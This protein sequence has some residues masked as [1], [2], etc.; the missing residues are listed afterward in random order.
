M[1]YIHVIRTACFAGLV[2]LSL[3]VLSACTKEVVSPG[4]ISEDYFP[5]ING[6]AWVTPSAA[7]AA[8][9]KVAVEVQYLSYSSIKEVSGLQVATRRVGTAT[10]IDTTR[11]FNMAYTPAF[12]AT[13]QC[14]TLLLMY[15]VP[16]SAGLSRTGLTNVRILARVLTQSGVYKERASNTFTIK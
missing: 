14:D 4:Q 10:V 15:S 13:K 3:F 7:Q 8:G 2:G 5:I 12:S 9:A 11:F 16:D 1:Q 6:N